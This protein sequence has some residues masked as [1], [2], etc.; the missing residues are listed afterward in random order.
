MIEYEAEL[1][2]VMG[3]FSDSKNVETYTNELLDLR[4]RVGM[5][6][7]HDGDDL[8]YLYR[9]IS[10]DLGFISAGKG[11]VQEPT[12]IQINNKDVT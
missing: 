1:G 3:R 10:R 4:G 5:A 12:T 8:N 9:T 6:I 2:S 7:E 11:I